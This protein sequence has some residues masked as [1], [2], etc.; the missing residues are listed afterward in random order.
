MI[1]RWECPVEGH[2]SWPRFPVDQSGPPIC[3]RYP[4][5]EFCAQEMVKVGY[6]PAGALAEWIEDW[7]RYLPSDTL[8]SLEK[9]LPTTLDSP[10]LN[11]KGCC[12]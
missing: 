11:L 3:G 12:T 7:K 9:L 4:T 10:A 2:G 8:R 5:G 1:E 6:I